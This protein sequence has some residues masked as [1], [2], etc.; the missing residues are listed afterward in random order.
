MKGFIGM[1]R[2]HLASR[3]HRPLAVFQSG[4]TLAE[5][6]IVVVIIA[7]LAIMF[8]L[9]NWKRNIFRA[10]DAR[11]KTDIA[12]IRR[13]FEEYYNDNGCYPSMDVLSTCGSETSPLKSYLRKIPCDP[14]TQE[15]Y[16]YQPDSDTNMCLGNRVCTKLQDWSDPDITTLGC[17]AQEGC[18][19][20]AYWNYCLATGT[21]VT[22]PGFN[23]LI[24]STPSPSPTPA[25]DGEYACRPGTLAG[26]QVVGSGTC[27]RVGD[28]SAFGCPRSFA[29]AD[30]QGLC[31][32]SG[33]WCAQ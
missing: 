22:A 26:G 25:Y 21:T 30:C 7:I 31:G 12:N 3:R 2:R 4:W 8:L 15:P 32:D 28:P 27:N 33:Y 9:I 17:N 14:T 6:L 23:P 5:L 20:G 18:G 29:E 13:A 19:W 16:K 1:K 24:T 11:R 10:Q